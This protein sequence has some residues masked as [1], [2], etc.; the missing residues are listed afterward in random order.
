M[1]IELQADIG[2]FNHKIKF[3]PSMSG[4]Y[5][6]T[7]QVL[8]GDEYVRISR[9]VE[10]ARKYANPDLTAMA[11]LFASMDGYDFD[12]FNINYQKGWLNKV[13]RLW[14]AALGVTENE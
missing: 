4:T 2:L 8:T 9:V 13:E 1:D 5:H 14:N 7:S 11:R 3:E 6:M 12:E 10:A